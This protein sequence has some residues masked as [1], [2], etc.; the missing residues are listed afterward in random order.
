VLARISAATH[1]TF[2]EILAALPRD[3]VDR[4]VGYPG[5]EALLD[6]SSP[7][8]AAIREALRTGGSGSRKGA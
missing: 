4:A 1:R 7:E 2:P 3:V 6:L 8:R 5:M